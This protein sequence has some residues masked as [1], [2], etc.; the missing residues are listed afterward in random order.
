MTESQDEAFLTPP[1]GPATP[2]SPDEVFENASQEP[3]LV[4]SQV[5]LLES[6]PQETFA[7]DQQN[8]GP[9]S[10]AEPETT[11][12]KK[13]KKKAK[14]A[15]AAAAAAFAAAATLEPAVEDATKDSDKKDTKDET[16]TDESIT[17]KTVTDIE[18]PNTTISDKI[19]EMEQSSQE[20]TASGEFAT[21]SKISE[22]ADPGPT[23]T[24]KGK[25][26]K[27][28]KKSSTL[29]P[30]SS[31]ENSAD[32]ANTREQSAYL[33]S[34]SGEPSSD[35]IPFPQAGTPT[36][37][38]WPTATTAGKKKR[39]SVTWAPELESFSTIVE[40]EPEIPHEDDNGLETASN[41][42]SDSISE[43]SS[44][45]EPSSVQDASRAGKLPEAG[46]PGDVPTSQGLDEDVDQQT[47][48]Y[49]A[50]KDLDSDGQAQV[51]PAGE[52]SEEAL[53][54]L[55]D[56]TANPSDDVPSS[57][58]LNTTTRGVA[59]EPMDSLTR[60]PSTP[61]FSSEGGAEVAN[62]KGAGS[63][64]QTGEVGS[65]DPGLHAG[66]EPIDD[67]L[68]ENTQNWRIAD[69]QA[70]GPALTDS[71]LERLEAGDP[72]QPPVTALAN[73]DTNTAIP[74][75]LGQGTQEGQ[76]PSQTSLEV[77]KKS[78][79]GIT[80]STAETETLLQDVQQL[81]K[82]SDVEKKE[83]EKKDQ[84]DEFDSLAANVGFSGQSDLSESLGQ[85][86]LPE[87]QLEPLSETLPG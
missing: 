48:T 73:Q 65:Q 59:G 47:A 20:P 39:K 57:T 6:K 21:D 37:A 31:L 54:T 28:G 29:D 5:D 4:D 61:A 9:E 51:H 75:P 42:E 79:A 23:V 45:V 17:D 86:I 27:K 36:E 63:N 19:G 58:G 25:K 8:R 74:Q 34:P 82:I 22:E 76:V 70:V 38:E 30:E 80:D 50:E 10:P 55:Q 11:S 49:V 1:Q 64:A 7:E 60:E 66:V 85:P 68:L 72:L 81:D 87:P 16:V 35:E 15:A 12:S 53:P 69:A 3:T 67:K 33:T 62:E 14:K 26:K 44:A 13:S 40:P 52:P 56:T 84:R 32:V 78:D 77:G 41:T 18:N 43:A 2:I 46:S 83:E 24:K 71:A